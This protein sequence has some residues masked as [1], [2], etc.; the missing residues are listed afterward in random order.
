MADADDDLIIILKKVLKDTREL[1]GDIDEHWE[2]E[3]NSEV[4]GEDASLWI[5]ELI[6]TKFRKKK[7]I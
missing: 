6:E 4:A 7:A 1:M 3:F 2:S 5:G